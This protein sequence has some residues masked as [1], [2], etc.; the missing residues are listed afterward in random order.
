MKSFFAIE[1]QRSRGARFVRDKSECLAEEIAESAEKKL[2]SILYVPLR[3]L[4]S[5]AAPLGTS[6]E[7]V[8]AVVF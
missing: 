3:A 2:D 7:G 6:L 5:I 1:Y 4:T 8:V